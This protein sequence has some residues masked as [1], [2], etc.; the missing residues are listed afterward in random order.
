MSLAELL[1]II[2]DLKNKSASSSKPIE[3][4]RLNPTNE[5]FISYI[6]FSNQDGI[7]I[8]FFHQDKPLLLRTKPQINGLIIDV[9]EEN[10]RIGVR[11]VP[12]ENASFEVFLSLCL[13][14]N[15]SLGA[16]ATPLEIS[17]KLLVELKMWKL[18]FGN[19]ATPLSVE[20]VIGLAG[21]LLTLEEILKSEKMEQSKALDSWTGRPRGMHDFNLPKCILEVKSSVIKPSMY[22]NI[23][24]ASQLDDVPG[25]QLFLVHQ[26][27]EF[28]E[29]GISLN[30]LVKR[31]QDRF[32]NASALNAFNQK[33]SS[34]GYHLIHEHI[35]EELDFLLSTKGSDVYEVKDDFPRLISSELE[36]NII[37]KSYAIAVKSCENFQADDI[38]L[39]LESGNW[40]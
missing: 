1:T 12:E 15:Q 30:S 36:P 29:F 26:L 5:K 21:E 17:R 19:G 6:G 2:E 16:C 37:I 18:F 13:H 40:I 35:Y 33:V 24:V 4:R 11:L 10:K 32:K 3:F 39:Q 9:V 38:A 25:R 34:A 23:S 31:L 14:L 7:F 20:S 8:A 22:F 27:F 28:D